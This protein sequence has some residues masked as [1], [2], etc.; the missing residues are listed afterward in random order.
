MKQI[1]ISATGI[2][3]VQASPAVTIF[4]NPTNSKLMIRTSNMHATG[5]T[6][7]DMNGRKVWQ[8]N[9]APEIDISTLTPGI[10]TLEITGTEGSVRKRLEKM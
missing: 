9:F 8:Q 7:Y 2:A 4:P 1:D 10:Y 3:T 5:I 6:I